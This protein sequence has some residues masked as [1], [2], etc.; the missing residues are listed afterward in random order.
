MHSPPGQ[1]AHVGIGPPGDV[2]R[3]AREALDEIAEFT[4]VF[5]K[6][7]GRSAANFLSSSGA[8]WKPLGQG[9]GAHSAIH[10]TR[11]RGSFWDAPRTIFSPI[12]MRPITEMTDHLMS[13]HVSPSSLAAGLNRL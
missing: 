12:N 11:M 7:Y 13:G 4:H 8:A 9:I 6:L 3:P 10:L 2:R 5:L 1:G